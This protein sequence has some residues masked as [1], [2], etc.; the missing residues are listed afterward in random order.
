MHNLPHM[1]RSRQS[2]LNDSLQHLQLVLNRCPVSHPDHTTALTN[3]AY[4]CLQGYIRN[5]FQG[6]N[7][8]VS[9]FRDALALRPQHHPDHHLSLYNLATTLTW[10]HNKKRAVV[11]IREAA[12]L[13]HEL[14]LLCPKDTYLRSI[15]AGAASQSFIRL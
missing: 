11:D 3:L 10:R 8:I 9:H 4:V 1:R 5:G 15:A 12:R 7:T 2:R 13:Y 6:I 14:L